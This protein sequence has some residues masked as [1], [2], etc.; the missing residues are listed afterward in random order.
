MTTTNIV[1]RPA[2]RG[3]KYLGHDAANKKNQSALVAIFDPR[4]GSIVASS[5]AIAPDP[6]SAGP[7]ALMGCMRRCDAYAADSGTVNV[8]LSVDIDEPRDFFIA[9]YGPL[10][11]PGQARLALADIT[12]LPGV[13]IGLSPQFPEG[14][15]IEVPG[16]C[17]SGVQ[18]NFDATTLSCTAK[19]TMMCG[20]EIHAGSADPYWPWP[21]SD[22]S[23]QLVTYMQSGKVYTYQMEYDRNAPAPS[24]FSG[25]W[26]N[27]ASTG[28]MIEQAWVYASEPKLGN[29]GSHQIHLVH[30]EPFVPD[31]QDRMLS[32]LKKT[33]LL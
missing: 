10:S 23:I 27:Q 7:L 1:I 6:A 16:L 25:Q 21:D 22:F 9:V 5:H 28:D 18:K 4:D 13:D 30:P 17:I 2:A 24:V 3:G 29:Q 31:D 26:P 19:V 32:L 15:V 20:C 14:L 8:Q 12:V 33:G 11:F